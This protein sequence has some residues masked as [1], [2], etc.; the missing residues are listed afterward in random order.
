MNLKNVRK[1]SM[2][3]LSGD[4]PLKR[5]LKETPTGGPLGTET[6]RSLGVSKS[7]AWNY[8]QAGWLTR[9]DH[10]V[11]MFAND[12]LRRDASLTF[13]A[14]SIPG[15]HVAGKTALDWHGIRH[16][17]AVREH[18]VL[19][20]DVYATLPA[21]FTGRFPASYASRH[22][23]NPGLARDFALGPLPETPDGP[24]VSDPERALLEMLSEVGVSEGAEDARNIM[25]GLL[26]VRTEVM[27]RL[28]K[29][30]LRVKAVRLCTRWAE[31][32][33]LEWAPVALNAVPEAVR[34]RYSL[35]HTSAGAR[36][37]LNL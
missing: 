3:V 18:L 23:F 1:Y 19:L 26:S 16:N 11:Y 24:L 21:W 2:P 37:V 36:P 34:H 6:L 29:A 7:H 14:K 35:G 22:L 31:E 17:V 25:E 27:A 9:L 13:L 20:G 5:L 12:Y 8:V 15:L 4:N 28:V 30:C 10:G 33:Q 32:M